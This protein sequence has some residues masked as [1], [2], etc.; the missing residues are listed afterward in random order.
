MKNK[1]P[2]PIEYDVPGMDKESI[3]RSLCNHLTLSI[4]KHA[5]SATS[6]D[7]FESA[8]HS[9]RDRLVERWM[10]TMQTYYE[11]DAKRVYYLSLEFLVGRTFSNAVLNLEI[12]EECKAALLELGHEV[13]K[14]TDIR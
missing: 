6:R 8:A 3:K 7:W 11:K 12:Q 14:L 4:S 2:S 9:V 1:H 13:E 5:G 10:E